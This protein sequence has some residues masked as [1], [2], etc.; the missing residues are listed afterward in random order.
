MPQLKAAT[1]AL[2]VSARRRVINDKWRDKIRAALKN[3]RQAD[4][5]QA[6]KAAAVKNAGRVL[7]RAARRHIIHWRTAAR[8]KSRLARIA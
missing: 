3:I 6:K 5:D 2:R 7:D 4:S 8:R 1:K